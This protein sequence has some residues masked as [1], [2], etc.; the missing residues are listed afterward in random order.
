[1]TTIGV[2]I[3]VSWWVR[4]YLK[5]IGLFI[6]ITGQQPDIDKINKTVLRGVRV[7]IK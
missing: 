5:E 2:K 1:M 3:C 7:E 4:P 6:A